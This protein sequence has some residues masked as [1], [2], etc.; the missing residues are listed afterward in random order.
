MSRRPSA[1]IGVLLLAAA[2]S[3]SGAT[4]GAQ[5]PGRDSSKKGPLDVAK[6]RGRP[7]IGVQRWDMYSGRGATQAQ[8]LGYLPGKQGFLKDAEW[9]D[10]APF[11]CRL[12]KDVDRVRHPAGA[13]PLWFNHPFSR[14][15]LQKTMDQEIRYAHDAGIDFFIY[16]GPARKLYANGWELKNNLDCH[17]A[18]KVP[19]AGKMKFVWALYGHSAIKYTRSKVAAMMDETMEYVVRPNWQRVMDHRPLVIVLWPG[20]FKKDLEGAPGKERMSGAEFVE[21]VRSRVKAKGFKNPYVV[22]CI[23]PA[24]SFRHAA[25]LKRDGYDAFADY[26]GSYG[27]RVGERDKSPTYAQATDALLKT[28]EKDFLGKGLPFL[29]PVTSMQYPWPRALDDKTGKPKK[30]WYHYQWPKKGDVADRI[31]RAFD[32]VAAHPKECEAQTVTMYSWNEHSEGGGLCP[33]MGEPPKYEPDT[34]WLDEAAGALA[35]WEY[36]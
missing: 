24:R 32:F 18:S 6:A 16:N 23:V 8:E 4:P 3:C 2:A 28:F 26:A 22:G 9:H 35:E 21:Y 19:E 30:K 13:G 29:P 25:E 33:T 12:A 14:E 34:T 10:R 11:F 31:R 1:A 27:G 17:M 5:P 7:L 15:L 20:T 36:R